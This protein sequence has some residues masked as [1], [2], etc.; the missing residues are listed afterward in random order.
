MV[1]S[2]N[3]TIFW[4][5]FLYMKW[6]REWN[7]L[8]VSGAEVDLHGHGRD[9]AAGMSLISVHVPSEVGWREHIFKDSVYECRIDACV[10]MFFICHRL[11]A[12]DLCYGPA[13][14]VIA[15]I[16]CTPT[17]MLW[18]IR[19]RESISPLNKVG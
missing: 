10:M 6:A 14:N 19:L 12:H 11:S 15:P 3:G 13:A 18:S 17:L 4:S 9:D 16:L 7:D 2:L 5:T 8:G 1:G